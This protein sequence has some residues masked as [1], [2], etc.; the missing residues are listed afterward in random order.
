MKKLLLTVVLCL[1]VVLV[2]GQKKVLNE[3]KKEIGNS[4]PN[5]TDARNL[6][7]QA[8]Q[9]VET[10]GQAETWYV[11]GLI[12]NKQFDVERSKEL[13][14]QKADDK[15]MYLALKGI[16][17]NFIIA[18][19]LDMSPD[20][21]GK[22]KSKYRKDMKAIMT[23]NKLYYINGGA[24]FFEH[25]DYQTAYDL[26]QQ[27]L[28]IPNMKMFEGENLAATDSLYSQIKFYSAIS[29]SQLGD[30]KKTIA[31]YL[32]M[33]DDGYKENEVYQYLCYEYEQTKDTAGLIVALKEGAEKFPGESYY[34]LSLINQYIYTNQNDEAISYLNKAISVKPD[35]AQ[36]YDVLGRIYENKGEFDK[37][38]ESF[39]KSISL[40]PTYADAVGN[41]GRIYY[42]QAVEAQQIANEIA[43]NNKYKTEIAKVKEMFRKALPYFEKAHQ[44]KPDE[45][46][47]MVA[48]RG[49]YYNLDMGEQF[50]KI[51][52]EL[53]N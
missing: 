17:P 19:S 35:D 49:I 16:M 14:G 38:E 4:S 7:K 45:R 50:D 23:A 25:K 34:L 47:Y 33:K 2:F 32:D 52:K 1:S 42:N 43:D 30:P 51:E 22:V 18:D 36:L 53:G 11:A 13:I 26:F 3:A 37:A 29:L 15:T 46:D 40:D 12:E 24:Y 27:Y 20:A 5:F 8:L 21:K 48:L 39:N 44:M 6:I 31:A 41:L 10:K 28:N 9:D